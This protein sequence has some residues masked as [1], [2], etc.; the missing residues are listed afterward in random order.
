MWGYRPIGKRMTGKDD[1]AKA[2]L[3][4]AQARGSAA[5]ALTAAD[6]RRQSEPTVIG[7]AAGAAEAHTLDGALRCQP[8]PMKSGISLAYDRRKSAGPRAVAC[9]ALSS[10]D[11]HQDVGVVGSDACAPFRTGWLLEGCVS[12]WHVTLTFSLSVCPARL[13]KSAN[14]AR[15]GG[16]WLHLPMSAG[17][18][19]RCVAG[20][21]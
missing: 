11:V 1:R 10:T 19:H 15:G 18:R 16:C 8:S 14:G 4:A 17:P 6:Y 13:R 3:G 5:V 2:R 12:Q 20:S 7:R 21:R 9:A